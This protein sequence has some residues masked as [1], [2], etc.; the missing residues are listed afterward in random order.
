M[1]QDVLVFSGYGGGWGYSG[2]SV[3][4][5]RFCADADVLLGG[6]GLF[7]GRGEYN[8]KIKVLKQRVKKMKMAIRLKHLISEIKIAMTSL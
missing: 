4:A 6:L 3:E 7:G 8:A 5:L 1:C 2:H